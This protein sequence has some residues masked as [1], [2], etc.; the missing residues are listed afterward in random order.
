MAFGT[1]ALICE[2]F[3]RREQDSTRA[4]LERWR[5]EE[6]ERLAVMIDPEDPEGWMKPLRSGRQ[7]DLPFWMQR[8]IAKALGVPGDQLLRAHRDRI[9]AEKNDPKIAECR[10]TW[11]E[12]DSANIRNSANRKLTAEHI[13]DLAVR[14]GSGFAVLRIPAWDD[15]DEAIYW[16]FAGHGHVPLVGIPVDGQ[17]GVEPER[18]LLIPRRGVEPILFRRRVLSRARETRIGLVAIIGDA[19]E[20]ELV[21]TNSEDFSC[22]ARYQS[23]GD[24]VEDGFGR[25]QVGEG[26]GSAIRR[27]FLVRAPVGFFEGIGR[28]SG[29][30]IAVK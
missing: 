14:F 8:R 19:G 26:A 5:E 28:Q 13:A 15:H 2:A 10:K 6:V 27:W 18:L 17:E 12:S 21:N 7:T 1:T 30:E 3:K 20:V 9:L 16:N 11:K 23:F 22:A 29:G 24:E 4:L 25:V